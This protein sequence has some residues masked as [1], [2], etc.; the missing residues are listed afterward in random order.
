MRRITTI[1]IG[2]GHAGLAMSRCLSVRGIDHIVLERGEIGNSWRTERWDSL[3]LLTP[4]WQRRLPGL[5]DDESDPDGFAGL[6]DVIGLIDRYAGLIAAPVRTHTRVVSVRAAEKGYAVFTD[7]GGWLCRCVVLASGACNIACVPG[8]AAAL[9]STIHTLTAQNYRNPAQIE[10]GGVLVVG[11]SASG[12]QIAGELKASGHP[13][14]LAVGEH[15]RAPRRYRGQDILWWMDVAG[16]LDQRYDDVDDIVRARQVP[17]LQLTGSHDYEILDLNVLR[18]KGVRIVGRLAGVNDTN[19]LFS[20]SLRN[21]CALSD[22]KMNR[23]LDAI[24]RWA[25]DNGVESRVEPPHRFASTIPDRDPPL[26]LDVTKDNIKTVIW[27]TGY[28]PDYSWLHMPVFDR[29]GRIVHDGGVVGAPG[30]YVMGLPFL[31]RRKSTFI[32]GAG[33]D[34]RDLSAHLDGYLSGEDNAAM[35][36]PRRANAGLHESLAVDLG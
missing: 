17:S 2:A 18:A 21:Q 24:D 33:D 36:A 31:R 14:T 28:R 10:E 15:I 8:I 4:N 23:L 20:G 26:K 25:A 7:Q 22:L 19:L 3:R 13:V 9:P 34:A 29:K 30:V 6:K 32:D 11:A 1:I 16:L 35:S 5:H 27:A 12:M